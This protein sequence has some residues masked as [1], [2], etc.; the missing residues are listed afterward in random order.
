VRAGEPVG[1]IS[2]KNFLLT[3]VRM[4]G[5]ELYGKRPVTELMER[6]VFVVDADTSCEAINARARDIYGDDRLRPFVVT[7]NGRYI[8]VGD[9]TKLM[10]VMADLATAR[11]S[12]LEEETRRAEA[13]S[14]SKTQFLA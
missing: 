9:A 4:Y 13:A 1:L 11:A 3:Y 14:A 5:A 2:R 10:L 7:Q 6:E 8:G 12:A